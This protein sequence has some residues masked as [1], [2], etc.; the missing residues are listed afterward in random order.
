MRSKS[1][2]VL[3]LVLAVTSALAV[4]PAQAADPTAADERPM[5]AP[6][7]PSFS[8][9]VE[10]LR[11]DRPRLFL[12]KE[13]WPAMRERALGPGK[14]AYDRMKQTADG[15]PPLE[16]ITVKDW[17]RELAPSAFVYRAMRDK[18]L[19]EKIRR[20]LRASLE[21][22]RR[23]LAA[24]EDAQASWQHGLKYPFTRISWLAALDWVWNDLAPAERQALASGMVRHAH[25]AMER[26]PGVS[27]GGSF[28]RSYALHWY[29][30]LGLLCDEL[31]DE[32]TRRALH[33]L[34][35]GY[36]DHVKMIRTR[37]RLRQDDGSLRPRIEYALPAYPHAEWSFFHTWRAAVRRGIPQAW[38]HS[39][40]I[41]N[42]A[43]WNLLP[44]FQHFGLGQAWH[45][46]AYIRPESWARAFGGYLAQHIFFYEDMHPQLADLSR[47][48]WHRM[49]YLR[50]GK[51]GYIPIWSEI[52]SPVDEHGAPLPENLPLARHFAGNGTVLLRSGSGTEDTYALFN[53]GG[54]V[55]CSPQFDA[56][57]F[58][59][60]KQ[61]FLA[62][63][64]GTRNAFPHQ[65][66]YY[67]QSVAH[68]CV[69]IRMPGEEFQGMYGREAQT[70]AGGQYRKPD[71]ANTVAFETHG[72]FAYAASDATETYR[73]DKCAQMV[74]QFLYIAP[75]YFVI[76]DRVASTNAE[77]PK[78][79]LLHTSNEPTVMGNTFRADQ[80]GGRM[81]C[82]VHYPTDAQFVKIGGPG[83]EFWADG[84]NWPLTEDW[85]QRFGRGLDKQVPE[86]MGR[87]RVEVHPG[88]PREQD[89]FL[90]LIQAADQSV[91]EMVESSAR[92]VGDRI[93]L[94]FTV[95]ARTY[96][97]AL[98]KTG[99][100]GGHIRIEQDGETL[101]DRPLT[102]EIMPQAGLA[103][104]D[105]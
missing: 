75:D 43:F 99:E 76:F 39:A 48:L 25:K 65:T 82:R 67:S 24:S 81:F 80:D 4:G 30:G 44:D 93:Q 54:G 27:Y 33:L 1:S 7:V 90:H 17:G 21:Q 77:Y 14:W 53:P 2:A 84:Q 79:W 71:A 37:A 35:G 68:N 46:P 16:E 9:L 41:P 22:Y 91:E 66:E 94:T 10:L 3:A 62:L 20:M 101:I 63:D 42:H 78:K 73:P 45:N 64:T 19:L 95:G 15:L 57:H 92:E 28:Y 69:L 34:A 88:A 36:E 96:T 87:W 11:R 61:G 55:D 47:H 32:D 86:I 103:L 83:K 72:L 38:H 85:W 23:S 31:D 12:N 100:V 98:N 49:D 56:T 60:Y 29:A 52:W 97:I 59:I 6:G 26:F 40:L 8:S 104:Q 105:N 13:M 70:N 74:R 18:D 5:F 102:Q 89:H 50:A 51:Y 58:A